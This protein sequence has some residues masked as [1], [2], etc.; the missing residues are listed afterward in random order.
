MSIKTKKWYVVAKKGIKGFFKTN[1]IDATTTI[2]D[3]SIRTVNNVKEFIKCMV[4]KIPVKFLYTESFSRKRAIPKIRHVIFKYACNVKH[5]GDVL[6][7]TLVA[8]K[9][10]RYSLFY[11][12]V[13]DVI[14]I[15]EIKQKPLSTVSAHS[16]D[17][18]VR[19]TRTT[20]EAVVRQ[21]SPPNII[22]LH[23]VQG[24]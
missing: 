16:Y 17:T 23:S 8:N 3:C 20:K 19:K 6:H 18:S 5:T 24:L 10:I 21:F 4:E 7:M 12:M 11:D 13:S 14:R 22:P 15:K 1:I 9:N 2:V